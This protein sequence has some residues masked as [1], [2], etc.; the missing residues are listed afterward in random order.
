MIHSIW[1]VVVAG[2]SSRSLGGKDSPVNGFDDASV[3]FDQR[4]AD[5]FHHAAQ[6]DDNGLAVLDRVVHVVSY[7]RLELIQ[8]VS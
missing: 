4:A 3:A 1:V 5:D 2:H 6:I 7:L 8:L